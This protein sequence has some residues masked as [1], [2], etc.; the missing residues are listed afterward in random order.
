MEEHIL[1]IIEGCTYPVLHGE[2]EMTYK[3]RAAKEITEHI[4]EFVLWKDLNTM[5]DRITKKEVKYLI[6]DM[7]CPLSWIDLKELYQYW[8]TQKK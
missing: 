6:A 7:D 3:S 1:E 4:V 8:L 5:T 2:A